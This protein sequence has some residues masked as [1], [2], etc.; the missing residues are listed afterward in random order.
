MRKFVANGLCIGIL[1]VASWAESPSRSSDMVIGET[2][3]TGCL[4]SQGGK[5]LLQGRKGKSTLLS[6]SHDLG[7]QVGHT[8]TAQGAFAESQSNGRRPVGRSTF[9]VSKLDN[10]SDTCGS[11]RNKIAHQNFDSAGKPSPNH[12]K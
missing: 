1:G 12:F 11:E 7:T 9:V 4:I 10:V 2:K 5:F 3:L 6:G 8:V